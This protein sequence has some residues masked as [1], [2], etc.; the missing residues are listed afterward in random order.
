MRDTVNCHYVMIMS[1]IEVAG[2]L[3]LGDIRDSE[4]ALAS[5]L[6]QH[7]NFILKI[8][9]INGLFFK[10]VQ[11]LTMNIHYFSEVFLL[12]CCRLPTSS[13]IVVICCFIVICFVLI[14]SS[15]VFIAA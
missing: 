3:S 10:P 6:F 11:A 13:E 14:D 15:S 1:P 12:N 2:N 8:L 5:L 9:Y 4:I 7:V